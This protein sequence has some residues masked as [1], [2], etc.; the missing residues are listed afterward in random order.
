M[1]GTTQGS[2]ASSRRPDSLLVSVQV[3]TE[4]VVLYL[5]YLGFPNRAEIESVMLKII[6]RTILYR[7]SHLEVCP[8]AGDLIYGTE[9]RIEDL[10]FASMKT[11]IELKSKCRVGVAYVFDGF[12]GASN[13]RV[14]R[15]RIFSLRR[16]RSHIRCPEHNP[17][18]E[19]TRTPQPCAC[20]PASARILTVPM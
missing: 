5:A 19:Y 11:L 20:S 1:A 10:V 6:C 15:V 18:E 4:M 16:D 7:K 8:I 2:H 17:V 14:C 9:T 13:D 3:E 12:S